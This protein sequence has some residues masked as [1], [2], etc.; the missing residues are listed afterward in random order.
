M[1]TWFLKSIVWDI[2]SFEFRICLGFGAWDF[3]FDPFEG[4]DSLVRF[5]SPDPGV[6]LHLVRIRSG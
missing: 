4:G 5:H 6:L 2:W 3:E 1:R